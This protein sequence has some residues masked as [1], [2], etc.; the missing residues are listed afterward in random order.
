VKFQLVGG[1]ATEELHRDEAIGWLRATAASTPVTEVKGSGVSNGPSSVFRSRLGTRHSVSSS[2]SRRREEAPD[3]GLLASVPSEAKSRRCNRW[4]T[5]LTTPEGRFWV[6]HQQCDWE[7]DGCVVRAGLAGKCGMRLNH[8][9][10]G[11]GTGWALSGPAPAD[12]PALGSP[13]VADFCLRGPDR[14]QS[15]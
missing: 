3:R 4:R 2:S 5:C 13:L 12:A 9:E 11:T 6:F 1:I 7:L 14:R 15:R 10:G 8:D